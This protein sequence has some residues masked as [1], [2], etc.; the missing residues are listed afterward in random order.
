MIEGHNT[1]TDI[2]GDNYLAV[3]ARGTS[4]PH[5]SVSKERLLAQNTYLVTA[6][7]D[8]LLEHL[9]VHLSGPRRMP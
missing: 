4:T 2:T 7:V 9:P 3:K 1:T 5:V 6:S 8:Q